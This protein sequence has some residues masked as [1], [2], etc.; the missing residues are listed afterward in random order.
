MTDCLLVRPTKFSPPP[1]PWEGKNYRHTSAAAI[2]FHQPLLFRNCS[3][4]NSFQASVGFC[5]ETS[6]L[7]YTAYQMTSFHMQHWAEM[8]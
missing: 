8:G 3:E 5:I 4:F 6:N 2:F 7:I 1:A